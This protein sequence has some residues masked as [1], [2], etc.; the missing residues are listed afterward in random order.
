MFL[1][2]SV[3]LSRDRVGLIKVSN[4]RFGSVKH[5]FQDRSMGRIPGRIDHILKLGRISEDLII[6][7]NSVCYV[8]KL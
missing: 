5:S 7:I 1:V 6:I 8:V 2:S 3:T 4:L